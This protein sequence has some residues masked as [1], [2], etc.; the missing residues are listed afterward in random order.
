MITTNENLLYDDKLL[1]LIKSNFNENDMELFKLNY[2][3]YIANK[4]N[5]DEFIVDF[6]EV[7]K[8]IGF[9]RKDNAKRLLESK[10]SENKKIFE[11]NKDYIIKMNENTFPLERVKVN[12]RPIEII[13]LTINC[14][15]K[16]CLKASTDKAD[17]IYDYYIK[18]EDIITKYIENKNNEILYET[19]QILELKNQEFENNKMLLEDTLTKLHLKNQEI[20][21]FKNRKYEEI[22]KTKNVYIFSCDKPNIY[23]IGKSK[24]VEQ[25]KKQLQTAN[26]DTII[27][28]HTRP[29]SD[30]YLLELI[31]HSILDQYRCK[32]NGEHFTANLDYMIMVI[33]MAEIFFDTLRSTYEYITKEEF[34]QKI[35]ENIL[36]QLI[37]DPYELNIDLILESNNKLKK[38]N[39][40]S[41]I[42]Q[43]INENTLP[44][45]DTIIAN[46]LV[47]NNI[48]LS[49][50]EPKIKFIFDKDIIIWFT[51]T[52]K[53]T[54]NNNDIIKVKD[55]YDIF[56]QSTYY[57]NMTKLDRIKYNKTFFV[58]FIETNHFFIKYYCS[59]NGQIRTFIKCWKIN[60][61]LK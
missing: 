18:M 53:L 34:L 24:D 28:H 6:N 11:I 22:Q 44:I 15:K 2:K 30:D 38:I 60:D 55:I 52:F 58:N 20:D 48:N 17:K 54:K 51:D 9:T 12:G 32:S 23:K 5:I 19:N 59:T 3:F 16:F 42:K 29:T 43:N 37:I 39:K 46:N 4:N 31:V 57:K 36:N 49:I 25:R 33:D 14:F 8:W 47:N 40:K 21:T 45:T 56:K 50:I 27:I 7:Y 35:N 13:L 1:N 41:I 10:N 26:V 61:S